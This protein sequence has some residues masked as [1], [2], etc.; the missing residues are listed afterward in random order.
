MKSKKKQEMNFN[1]IHCTFCICR[2]CICRFNQL[3]M[4]FMLSGSLIG[5]IRGCRCRI[6][7]YGWQRYWAILSE[8]LEHHQILVSP[9]FWKLI[10]DSHWGMIAYW[11]I[12]TVYFVWPNITKILS[13]QN[14]FNMQIISEI[15]YFLCDVFAICCVFCT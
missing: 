4:D 12:S 8:G 14:V 5:W 2:L 1:H 11:Y 13:F 3:L 9:G 6:H 10:H 15:F 7:G